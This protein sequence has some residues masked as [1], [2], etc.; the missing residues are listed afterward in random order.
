MTCS[1]VP[2]T[3]S[4]YEYVGNTDCNIDHGSFFTFHN[5]TYFASGGMDNP[6]QY[7]RA[8]YITP[9]YYRENGEIVVDQEIMSYGSGQYDATMPSISASWYFDAPYDCKKENQ[10]GEFVACLKAVKQLEFSK[11]PGNT[12]ADGM[13]YCTTVELQSGL[14]TL[15]L[16]KT[17]NK[18]DGIWLDAITFIPYEHEDACHA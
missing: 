3:V 1:P 14:N 13:N 6:N 4:T 8:S 7:Y 5:Q 15:E 16:V 17:G 10:H 18:D 2:I 9:C 11:T 12:L